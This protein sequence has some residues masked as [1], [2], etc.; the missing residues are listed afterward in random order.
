VSSLNIDDL[1]AKLAGQVRA[2][3]A[4]T[5]IKSD[6]T[7]PV[8]DVDNNVQPLKEGERSAENERDVK[9]N[10]LPG[11]NNAPPAKLESGPIVQ[12]NQGTTVSA[13]GSDPSTEDDF[14]GN[15]DDT[16]TTSVMDF[17]DGE[18]YASLKNQPFAKLASQFSRKRDELLAAILV[19]KQQGSSMPKTAAT[20]APATENAA[21]AAA[22]AGHA[23]AA[24]AAPEFQIKQAHAASM[25]EPIVVDAVRAA[26]LFHAHWLK[27]SG[28]EERDPRQPGG[29]PEG[30]AMHG[31]PAGPD[32]GPAG[33]EM[34]GAPPMPGGPGAMPPGGPG[35][36]G[37]GDGDESP[38]LILKQL[39][40][41]LHE[42]GIPPEQLLQMAQ[43]SG[44]GGA[45]AP[46]P[47]GGAPAG[48][49]K[50]A[51]QYA[52]KLYQVAKQAA[53]YK[54]SGAWTYRDMK[55]PTAGTKEAHIRGLLLK[56]LQEMLQA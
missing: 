19:E 49:P 30:P 37:D 9:S 26:E 53:H 31:S 56:Q 28:E 29:M 47:P 22:V 15:K 23:A 40:S 33:P 52:P 43:A 25:I 36:M 42:I 7:H 10:E 20:S 51:A 38:E 14:K 44:G 4:S 16:P 24:L 5:S 2:K 32:G 27:V 46:P 6:T 41:A 48:V 35:G 54:A 34:G 13:A 55:Y 12:P 21:A 18:K 50:V 17:S 8:A 1:M 3:T 39:V 45:E 11:A